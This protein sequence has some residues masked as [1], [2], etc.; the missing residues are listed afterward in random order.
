MVEVGSI[1]LMR[2]RILYLLFQSRR[3]TWRGLQ[4]LGLNLNTDSV[5]WFAVKSYA[6]DTGMH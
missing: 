3:D 5:R 4:Y 2:Q 6:N 1:T